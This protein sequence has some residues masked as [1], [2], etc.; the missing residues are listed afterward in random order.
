MGKSLKAADGNLVPVIFR[1]YHE[2]DGDWFWW[3]KSHCTTDEFKFSVEV[4]CFLFA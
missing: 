4:H 3:G 1:P 2:F